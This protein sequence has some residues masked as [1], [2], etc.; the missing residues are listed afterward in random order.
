VVDP[1]NITNYNRTT[2]ELEELGLFWIL[3]ANQR[4]VAA[5]KS[6]DEFLKTWCFSKKA[7]PFSIVRR[8][9]PVPGSFSN[10]AHELRSVG[11]RFYN[12]KAKGL[13]QLAHSGLDLKTCSVADLEE[14]H[15]IGPKTAR[16][17]VLHSRPDVKL[18]VLDTHVLKYLRK[19]G[20][21]APKASPTG[22][23]YRDLEQLFLADAEAKKMTPAELDL[24]VW[25]EYA[26]GV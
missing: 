7:S 16:G 1:L 6:L 22:K 8:V 12:G 14:I 24:K 11:I 15:G 3:A 5:A 4:G 13:Q 25:R 10:L 19:L 20:H 17:F 9:A 26:H 2:N 18:A 21:E 23:K